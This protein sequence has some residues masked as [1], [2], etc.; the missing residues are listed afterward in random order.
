M[1][2]DCQEHGYILEARPLT[3]GRGSDRL[4]VIGQAPGHRSITKGRPWSGPGGRILQ[5]WFV[6]LFFARRLTRPGRIFAIFG[7]LAHIKLVY[8][9]FEGA[10]RQRRASGASH[11][12]FAPE[13]FDKV[14]KGHGLNLFRRHPLRDLRYIGSRGAADYAALALPVDRF[15]PAILS[16]ARMHAN[17]IGTSRIATLEAHVDM[18]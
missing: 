4:M 15:Q 1:R 10:E 12:Q 14:L 8:A 18:L 6:S 5:K 3:S 7:L 9:L 16:K 13:L 17:D 11:Y 2:G